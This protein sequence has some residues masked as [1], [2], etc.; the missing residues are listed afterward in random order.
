[1]K[2][3]EKLG[4]GT[5]PT[6]ILRAAIIIGSGSASYEIIEHLVKNLPILLIPR[7]ATTSCQPIGIRD[8]IKYL[9]GVLETCETVGQSFDIGGRDILT[10]REMLEILA[11]LL[12]KW[13]LFVPSPFSNIGLFA[14]FA[15]LC[16]P[17]PAPITR[18]LMEGSPT[19][20]YARTMTSS[21]S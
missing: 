13:R 11:N 19:W 4:C 16:T 9:V 5:V 18:C 20:S 15:S 12:G 1:M 10:Y 7:W 17:V 8:V 21:E 3:A 6:T 2:V 14:Y